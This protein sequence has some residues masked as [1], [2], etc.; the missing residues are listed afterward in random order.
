MCTYHVTW[1]S[2][3]CYCRTEVIYPVVL[4]QINKACSDV[5]TKDRAR[6]FCKH[7]PRHKLFNSSWVFLP[8]ISHYGY[9]SFVLNDRPFNQITFYWS[10]CKIF[11]FWL[12]LTEIYHYIYS[13]IFFSKNQVIFGLLLLWSEIAKVVFWY[14][15][16]KA[17]GR[18]TRKMLLHIV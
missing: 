8:K 14:M 1:N 4:P 12:Y 6:C 11:Y 5:M 7:I 16:K 15:N 2:C 18:K 10:Q 17:L 9:L 3:P 13:R